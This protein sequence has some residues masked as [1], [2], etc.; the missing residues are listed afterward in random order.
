MAHLSI[1]I[2]KMAEGAK[3]KYSILISRSL[4]FLF[5]MLRQYIIFLYF[6]DGKVSENLKPERRVRMDGCFSFL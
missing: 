6:D 5:H 2:L 3:T 4:M 1:R